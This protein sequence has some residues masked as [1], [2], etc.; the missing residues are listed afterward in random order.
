[1]QPAIQQQDHVQEIHV[2]HK[3][4]TKIDLLLIHHNHFR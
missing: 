4:D 3:H 2:N 1:M